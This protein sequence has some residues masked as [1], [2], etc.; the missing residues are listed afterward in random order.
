MELYQRVAE[1]ERLRRKWLLVAAEMKTQRAAEERIARVFEQF[2]VEQN[3]VIAV[4]DVRAAM[5]AVEL[6]LEKGELESVLGPLPEFEVELEWFKEACGKCLRHRDL[7]ERRRVEVEHR[8]LEMRCEVEAVFALW[9]L[10]GTGMVPFGDVFQGLGDCGWEPWKGLKDD[11]DLS[12]E[13]LV[14]MV[15]LGK[16]TKQQPMERS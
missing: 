5:R 6:Y 8:V 12:M 2:D 14:D 3:G 15:A 7:A 9:D 4:D 16:V 10:K 11:G 13:E 1:A